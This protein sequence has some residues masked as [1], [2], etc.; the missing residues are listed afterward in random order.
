MERRLR[1]VYANTA[2]APAPTT[3]ITGMSKS[4]APEGPEAPEPGSAGPGVMAGAVTG[5]PASTETYP[6][7]APIA[8]PAQSFSRSAGSTAV[9]ATSRNCSSVSR[10]SASTE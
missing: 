6:S 10:E 1:R 9:D 5:R 3:T 8:A 7:A 4:P 2:S